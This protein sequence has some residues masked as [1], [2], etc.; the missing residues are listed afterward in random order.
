MLL[1]R[2]QRRC[3]YRHTHPTSG[4]TVGCSAETAALSHRLCDELQEP[5]TRKKKLLVKGGKILEENG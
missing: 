1:Y 2:A 3:I 5:Q 4:V